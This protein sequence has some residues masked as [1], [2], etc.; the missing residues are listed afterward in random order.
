MEAMNFDPPSDGLDFNPAT[1]GDLAVCAAETSIVRAIVQGSGGPDNHEIT[2]SGLRFV[3]H[4][5]ST[6]RAMRF[7]FMPNFKDM[8]SIRELARDFIRKC[9]GASPALQTM[10]ALTSCE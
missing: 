8:D 3:R 2:D 7:G 5:L 6:S 1:P 10:H 9:G 4:I